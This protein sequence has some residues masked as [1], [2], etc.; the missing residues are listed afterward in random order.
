MAVKLI[1]SDIDGTLLPRGRAS[2]DPRVP[3]AFH[4]ALDAGLYVGP[5]S[6]RALPAIL[7]VFN[8]DSACVRTALT[9]NGM[10][11]YL[12][13]RLIHE[14]VLPHDALCALAD[15]MRDEPRGGMI[16]F[17][18]PAVHMVCGKAE[19]LAPIFPTY[20]A[21]PLLTWAVPATPVVKANVFIDA[22]ADE[23]HRLADRL[24]AV[25]PQLGF[26]VPMPG[27]L[28]VVPPGYSKATGIDIACRALGVTLDEVVVFGDAGNDIEMLEHVP[29]SV[30]VANATAEAAAVARWHIGSVDDCAVAD[31][32]CALAA[33]SWPFAG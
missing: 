22:D 20:A 28:N 27:F 26:N 32:I 21:N 25:V 15:I 33:G 14:E 18:G 1:L 31:A 4:A 6:G 12:D 2:L 7:P 16:C 5:V 10:Q 9:T 17:E 19:T 23:T 24:A 30:A 8:E 11:V 29:N 3:A 13:G